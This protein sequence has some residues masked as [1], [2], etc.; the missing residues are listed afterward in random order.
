MRVRVC[1]DCGEE[2]RP[3]IETCADCGGRVE[4][5]DVAPVSST[6]VSEEAED[7]EDLSESDFSESVL[8]GEKASDLANSADQLVEAGVPFR[9]RPGRTAGYRLM[10]P[11][12]D[13]DRALVVL[14]L[15]ADRG[16]QPGDAVRACP[17]CETQVN[18]G[19]A[20]CPECG[21]T[22]GD[23][24]DEGACERCG[25]SLHGPTCSVCDQ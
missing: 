1:V 21:L 14:G 4:D 22:V 5:P 9:L 23:E 6:R 8:G 17:A 11:A 13:R 2:Y 3:D 18:P 15:L 7:E 10:V 12:K 25:R 20:D 16:E 24:S 19:V